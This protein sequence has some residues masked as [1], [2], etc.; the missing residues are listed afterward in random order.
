MVRSSKKVQIAEAAL[1]LFLQNGFK[2]TSVDMV[3]KESGVSKPTIYKHFPD[4]ACLMAFVMESW[5]A[6][7]PGLALKTDAEYGSLAGLK[8]LLTLNNVGPEVFRLY[9]LVVAEGW[10]FPEAKAAFFAGFETACR[11]RISAWCEQVGV[12]KGEG[13]AIFSHF[14]VENLW[15]IPQ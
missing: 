11:E 1:P 3:V 5:L 2:G 13:Q 9:R 10:R 6:Q 14:I 7:F 12:S 15:A 4:K 8:Q